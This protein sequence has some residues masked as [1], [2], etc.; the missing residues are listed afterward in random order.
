MYKNK[1]FEEEKIFSKGAYCYVSDWEINFDGKE[2][3][4]FSAFP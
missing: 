2:V 3:R 1:K 4:N